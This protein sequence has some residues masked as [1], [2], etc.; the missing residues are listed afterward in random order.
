M[1][2]YVFE[3]QVR[4]DGVVNIMQP[5]A[6]SSETMA[7][8]YYYERCSKMSANDQFVSAH[9]MICDNHLNVL[10]RKDVKTSYVVPEVGGE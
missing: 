1:N 3:T 2:Y 4:T 5:I 7:F 6:R 8:S 9:V 10:D